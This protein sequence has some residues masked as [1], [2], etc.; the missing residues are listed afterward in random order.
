MLLEV[1]VIQLTKGTELQKKNI[2]VN[3]NSNKS[4]LILLLL[5]N[6][7]SLHNINQ[8]KILK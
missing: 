6:H 3:K 7:F 2:K 1:S 8:I 4:I 5:L